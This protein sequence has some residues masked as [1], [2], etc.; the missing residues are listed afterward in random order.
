ME[1]L[2]ERAG[3]V[4]THLGPRVAIVG[5]AIAAGG[6]GLVVVGGTGSESSEPKLVVAATVAVPTPTMT[7]VPPAPTATPEPPPPEPEPLPADRNDCAAI[8]ADPTY[9][10]EAERQ[11]F[12]ANCSAPSAPSQAAAPVTAPSGGGSTAPAAPAAPPPAAGPR[13]VVAALCDGANRGILV[14]K[15]TSGAFSYSYD[16]SS[17]G[18][19]IQPPDLVASLS[20]PNVPPGVYSYSVNTLSRAG[21][22]LQLASGQAEGDR[23]GRAPFC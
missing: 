5:L 18:L 1:T 6:V 22:Q 12:M 16:A 11:W 15:I 21:T 2:D 9:R 23:I 4:D 3:A 8:R 7:P 19:N 20:V 17:G 13:T 14:L 10:S